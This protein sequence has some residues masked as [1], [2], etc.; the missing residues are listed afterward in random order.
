MYE[1]KKSWLFK[2]KIKK[3]KHNIN[4]LSKLS[5]VVDYL[6]SWENIPKR[7]LDHEL[8]WNLKPLRELHLC[9]DILLIY[10]KDQKNKIITLTS[11]WNHNNV[12]KI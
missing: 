12:F 1:I 2:K 7:F 4:V 5:Q 3:Y 6:L 11:I 9:P 10:D 8:S